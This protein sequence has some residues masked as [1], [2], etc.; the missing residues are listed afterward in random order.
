MIMDDM[1]AMMDMLTNPSTKLIPQYQT[2]GLRFFNRP[3]DLSVVKNKETGKIE[4]C[5]ITTVYTPFSKD[6]IKVTTKS[7]NQGTRL[8]VEFNKTDKNDYTTDKLDVDRE[9]SSV[10]CEYSGISK[11]N[12]HYEFAI[13]SSR[14]DV[15]GITAKAEDGILSITIPVD[16]SAESETRV[17]VL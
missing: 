11:K 8:I 2:S 10:I 7:D 9:K 6:D 4:A 12:I 14:F 16:S 15:K 1:F 17:A 13:D 3:H 5:I